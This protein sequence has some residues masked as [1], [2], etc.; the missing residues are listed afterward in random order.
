MNKYLADDLLGKISTEMLCGPYLGEL[1][2]LKESPYKNQYLI[3]QILI[4]ACQFLFDLVQSI[5]FN[6]KNYYPAKPFS[7]INKIRVML[8]RLTH[9]TDTMQSNYRAGTNFEL[10]LEHLKSYFT[11]IQAD[12]VDI[13]NKFRNSYTAIKDLSRKISDEEIIKTT[14]YFAQTNYLDFSGKRKSNYETE[15]LLIKR[16]GEIKLLYKTTRSGILLYGIDLEW[17][18]PNTDKW[19][20]QHLGIDHSDFQTY[21]KT[22]LEVILVGFT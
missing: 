5:D 11:Y 10:A 17:K 1:D 18:L 9:F 21:L 2:V 12:L 19:L 13:E 8:N 7:E 3:M 4:D 20:N 6:I 14:Y 15:L 16:T 22:A